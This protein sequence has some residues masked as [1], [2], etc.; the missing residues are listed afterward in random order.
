[1]LYNSN[2]EPTDSKPLEHPLLLIRHAQAEHNVSSLLGGSTD[3]ALTDI[4]MR[5]ARLLA[6]RLAAELFGRRLHLG[7]GPL[8]RS[9]HTA[10]IIGAALGVEPII[11]PPLADMSIGDAAG[12]TD[13]EAEALY[14]PPSEPVYDWRPYP[15]AEN[16]RELCARVCGFIHTYTQAQDAPAILTTHVR[17]IEVIVAWW[18]GLPMDA[19]VSFDLDVASLTVLRVNRWGE[20]TI[21]RLNDT[22]H[23]Q[24]AGM[25]NPIHL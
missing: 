5:Q 12:L 6:K 15:G 10:R 3:T 23:L 8:D 11:F 22:A 16:W 24:T 9:L 13:D 19:N 2:M 25:P 4:G 14:T 1:M 21:E 20:R 7:A 17:P 18:L